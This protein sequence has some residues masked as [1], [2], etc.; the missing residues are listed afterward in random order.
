MKKR[1]A[2]TIIILLVSNS[3]LFACASCGC[4]IGSDWEDPTFSQEEGFRFDLKYDY[5]DQNKLMSGRSS[6]SAVTASN[7]GYEVEKYTKNEYITASLDYAFN[8]RFGLNFSLPYIVRDHSTLGVGPTNGTTPVIGGGSYE[9]KTTSLGDAKLIGRYL[10][11]DKHNLGILAG[12]K[13]ATGS[14][15]LMGTS[16]DLSYPVGTSA[17]IDRGLQPGTGTTDAIAGLYYFHSLTRMSNIFT[18]LMY[19]SALNSSDSYRPGDVYNVN[20]GVNYTGF[21][22]IIPKLQMNVKYQNHDT[23]DNADPINT[24][25]FLTYLTPGVMVNFDKVTLYSSVQIPV[26]QYVNGVQLV[27]D[28]IVSLGVRYNF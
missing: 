25:G 21:K 9:S 24:G 1:F 7:V 3:A 5:L 26:Y 4:S 14:H 27:P 6:I 20:I 15:S 17:A 23:G 28:Y 11:N 18:Q 10:I 19:Q 8:D 16:T 13:F 22:N 2:Y 12:L